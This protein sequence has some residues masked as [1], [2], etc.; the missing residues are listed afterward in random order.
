MLQTKSLVTHIVILLLVIVIGAV[1]A[2][3][4]L[5]VSSPLESSTVEPLLASGLLFL[6]ILLLLSLWL[7]SFLRSIFLR[8][9]ANYEQQGHSRFVSPFPFT[10]GQSAGEGGLVPITVFY[11]NI[12]GFSAYI[13][14][15][16]NETVI[17]TLHTLLDMQTDLIRELNGGVKTYIGDKVVAIFSKRE[18]ALDACKA[19]LRVQHALSRDAS[20]TFEGLKASIGIHTGEVIVGG[21]GS[22]ATTDTTII[23][24]SFKLA[25]RLCGAAAEGQIIISAETYELIG[26]LVHVDGPYRLKAKDKEQ[27]MTVYFLKEMLDEAEE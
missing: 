15:K 16:Q 22:S 2:F 25:S 6:L 1:S 17:R 23:G 21:P 27:F 20:N 12:R 4:T 11:S 7:S 18:A 3:L 24:D 19:A 8:S 13:D 10:S 9:A 5:T 14:H 26:E